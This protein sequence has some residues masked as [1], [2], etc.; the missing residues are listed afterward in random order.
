MFSHD[1]SAHGADPDGRVL[2]PQSSAVKDVPCRLKRGLRRLQNAQEMAA[3][4]AAQSESGCDFTVSVASCQG[5]T[6][7]YEVQ[8][9]RL[10]NFLTNSDSQQ[11]R[12][13]KNPAPMM[14]S[15]SC[16]SRAPGRISCLRVTS[17]YVPSWTTVR[18]PSTGRQ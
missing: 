17:G 8:L 11:S 14:S 9:Q 5:E 15:S 4:L 3:S 12:E 18:D 13:V 6:Q 7:Q 16:G 2:L 1:T 10:W